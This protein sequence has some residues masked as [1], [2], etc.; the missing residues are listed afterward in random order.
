MPA[1]T[2]QVW[3]DAVERHKKS[4]SMDRRRGL[5]VVFIVVVV[6]SVVV[7]SRFIEYR[8]P[9]GIDVMQN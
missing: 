9:E 1:E 4:R 6:V 2:L 7:V 5:K 3:A 8:I